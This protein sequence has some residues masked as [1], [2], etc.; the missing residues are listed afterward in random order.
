MNKIIMMLLF[1][2]FCGASHAQTSN[3]VIDL[4]IDDDWEQR[5]LS[6][7]YYYKQPNSQHALTLV[8]DMMQ[9]PVF[10]NKIQ[11]KWNLWIWGAQVLQ[12]ASSSQT[13]AW[14]KTLQTQHS[15]AHIA[16]IFLFANTSAAKRC[17]KSLPLNEQEREQL[18]QLPDWSRP[19]QMPLQQGL[20]L[21]MMWSV[22]FAT[23]NPKALHKLVD[24]VL[25]HQYDTQYAAQSMYASAMWSLHANMS[26]DQ[27]IKQIVEDYVKT[28][29]PIQQ[30]QWQQQFNTYSSGSL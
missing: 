6:I 8:S 26:E 7:Q 16:P 25:H 22:F 15:P 1:C 28:L 3:Q 20:D 21:D 5:S 2:V 10:E 17:L 23:G 29:H 24:F 14:C 12:Q 30:S 19:L 13:R 27:Q 9:Q 4:S 18:A 11:L